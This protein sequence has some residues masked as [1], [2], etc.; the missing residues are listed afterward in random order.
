M[1]ND[2]NEIIAD[3]SKESPVGSRLKMDRSAL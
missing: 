1:I 3:L 2:Q